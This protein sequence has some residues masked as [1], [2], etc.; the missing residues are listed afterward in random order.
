MASTIDN[1]GQAAI[2]SRDEEH[3]AGGR[4]GDTGPAPGGAPQEAAAQTV[5]R[6]DAAPRQLDA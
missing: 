5:A 6:Q 3:A 4:T 2:V 1:R